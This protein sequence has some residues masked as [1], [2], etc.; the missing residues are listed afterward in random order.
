MTIK[1][2]IFTALFVGGAAANADTLGFSIKDDGSTPANAIRVSVVD[3]FTKQ[4][5]SQAKIAVSE[6]RETKL[7]TDL[8]NAEGTAVFTFESAAQ[9]LNPKMISVSKPNYVNVSVIGTQNHIVTIFLKPLTANTA[10]VLAT[11]GLAGFKMPDTSDVV[12][13]GL[14]FPTLSASDLLGFNPDSIISPLSD[15]IDVMGPQKVPSNLVIPRQA[16]SVIFD[17][18]VLNKPTYKLPVAVGQPL[19]LTGIQGEVPVADLIDLATSGGGKMS[20]DLLNKLKFRRSAGTTD[21]ITP[22]GPFKKDLNATVLLSKKYQA[23]PARPDFDGNIL[24]LSAN[25]LL[26]DR[27]ILIPTD[28]KVALNTENANPIRT[29]SLAQPAAD[30]GKARVTLSLAYGNHGNQI[31]GVIASSATTALPPSVKT[32]A[33][34]SVDSLND[35]KGLPATLSLQAPQKGIRVAVFEDKTSAV[36]KVYALPAAGAYALQTSTLT[37]SAAIAKYALIDLDFG[38]TFI[39]TSIDGTT[40]MTGLERFARAGAKTAR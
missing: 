24:V 30:Y 6:I 40:L 37:S 12:V 8:T 11:G 2:I 32:G 15:T 34:M 1:R 39:E 13:A 21:I 28:V 31:S 3:E 33:F 29:V 19:R 25:D 5:L 17:T 35:S 14:V 38:S 10:P 23:T 22:S 20:L 9:A 7:K 4:P 26:G 18:I 36:W 16:F 27:S